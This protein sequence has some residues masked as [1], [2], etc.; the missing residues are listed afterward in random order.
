MHFSTPDYHKNVTIYTTLVDQ[1]G[2]VSKAKPITLLSQ[3]TNFVPIS[4]ILFNPF[5]NSSSL[6]D[7]LYRMQIDFS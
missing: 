4:S 2:A 7:I 3:Y 1:F 6:I 5:F